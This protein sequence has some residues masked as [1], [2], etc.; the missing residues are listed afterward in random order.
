MC[1]FVINAKLLRPSIF[2]NICK[3]LLLKIYPTT[4]LIFRRYFRSS[5]LPAF[6]KVSV[7]KTSVKFLGKHICWSLFSI[8]LPALRLHHGY[9][10]MKMFCLKNTFLIAETVVRRCSIRKA[11][12]EISQNLQE[13]TCVRESFLIKLQAS[14][15]RPATLIRKTLW[16]RC[17]PVNFA[18]FLRTP[19]FKE[20]LWWLLL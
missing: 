15:V 10:S 5:S 9:F 18:K 20:H 3:W 16:Y 14:G 8:N 7:L 19:F 12:L 17:F 6:Y 2:K 1:I 13:N 11:P 4:I